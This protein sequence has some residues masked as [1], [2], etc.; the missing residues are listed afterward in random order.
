MHHYYS[1]SLIQVERITEESLIASDPQTS[2]LNK[3]VFVLNNIGVWWMGTIPSKGQTS[4]TRN[5]KNT[6]KWG[7]DK[8]E[9]APTT[10]VK[11]SVLVS[12]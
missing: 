12:I 9:S 6:G 2:L 4:E 8:N 3:T 7:A 11:I 10:S 5:G 1:S